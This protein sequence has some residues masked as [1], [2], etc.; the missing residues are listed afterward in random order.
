MRRILTALLGLVLISAL[1]S[2]PGEAAQLKA[3]TN[4]PTKARPRAPHQRVSARTVPTLRV[5]VI[6][7]G[8]D[9]PW[10]VKAVG[11]GR[12]L[13]TE[14][15]SKRLLLLH[16]ARLR[17]VRYPSS[18]VWARGET[19]LMSLAVDPGFRRNRRFYTCQG[20]NLGGRRHDV[21]V[22]VWRLKRNRR[23]VFVRPLLTGLPSTSGQHGG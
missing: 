13:I 19:G 15:T 18:T 8:L 11:K 20:R 14:R 10:D 17:R 16:K 22:M 5:R 9:I 12:F 23:A 2:S 21:R 3:P 1:G 4:A 6:A 7:H